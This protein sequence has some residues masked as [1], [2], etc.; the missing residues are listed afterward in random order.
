MKF[1]FT[2]W[3]TKILS[4][5][6]NTEYVP[7]QV[8]NNPLNT[9]TQVQERESLLTMTHVHTKKALTCELMVTMRY[10]SFWG[11]KIKNSWGLTGLDDCMIP[12]V[13][14]ASKENIPNIFSSWFAKYIKSLCR[15][16]RSISCYV[17]IFLHPD[18]SQ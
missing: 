7:I 13:N 16:Y 8:W 14:D 1:W 17:K 10:A 6:K 2:S 11:Y 4:I 9:T 3:P 15:S 12:S 5:I 18:I